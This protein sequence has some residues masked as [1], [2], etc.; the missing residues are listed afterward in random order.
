[1]YA[2]KNFL[3]LINLSEEDDVFKSAFIIIDF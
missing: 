3:I 1:M 2:I